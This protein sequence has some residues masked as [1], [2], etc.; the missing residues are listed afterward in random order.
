MT[1]KTMEALKK[2][3]TNGDLS[4]RNHHQYSELVGTKGT[5]KDDY[6][7]LEENYQ[8]KLLRAGSKKVLEDNLD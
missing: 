6:D 4:F 1:F 5:T 2:S 7:F 8:G 3:Y